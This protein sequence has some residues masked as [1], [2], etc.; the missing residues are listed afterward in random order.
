M[1]CFVA[2]A[3]RND[4]LKHQIQFSNNVKMR[5]RILAARFARGLRR[6]SPY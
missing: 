1:D 4:G 5:V 2:I 6:L 3:P